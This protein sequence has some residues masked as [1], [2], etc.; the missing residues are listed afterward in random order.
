MPQHRLSLPPEAWPADLRERFETHPLSVHQRTRL[1]GAFGRWL[2]S[3]EGGG[4][5]PR[6]A[7]RETWLA[8]TAGLPR[9]LRN[10]VR[11]ALVIIFPAVATL[12]YEPDAPALARPDARLR[13]TRQIASNLARFPEDWRAAAQPL[14]H[15]DPD[16][17]VDG[18][19]VQAWAPATIVRRIQAAAL[20][21]DF[22]R[23]RGLE[24]DIKPG[25]VRAQLRADQA[26]VESGD[27]RIGG[28]SAHLDSLTCLAIAVRPDRSW[29]WLRI[30]RDAI[31]KVAKH[32]GSRNAA[33]AVDAAELRA[34]GQ[35]LLDKADARH[36]MARNRRDFV[37]AH[38]LARTALTMILLA[39]APVRIGSC[40]RIELR[41]SLL[42]DLDGL[43]LDASETKEKSPDRRAFSATLIDALSRYI[44]LHRAVIA[45]PGA[46]RLFV[47][48]RGGPIG[49]AQLSTCLGDMTEAPLQ[50]RVTP[51]AIRHSVANFIVAQVPEEA[52]L[53]TVIL[54]HRSASTT[55]VYLQ[56]AD[57]IIASRRLGA[58]TERAA[59]ELGANTFPKRKDK[60][61]RRHARKQPRC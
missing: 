54:N 51:H 52:A 35:Q 50:R 60:R 18:I 42:A 38:T 46:T 20:Y 49:A 30:T 19:L 56:R 15:V 44:R 9:S 11:Q 16:A 6:D 3:A 61:G 41:E 25:T 43:F 5:D 53:A 7:S 32:H 33:R 39:E 29:S 23:A 31:K 12:L 37:R 1:A 26:R 57:Q 14:L 22:C 24:V 45:R 59:R 17:V 40:A 36:A 8:Q 10:E 58:A 4:F 27:R 55:P 34:A 21:F 47:G 13:L 28:T 2:K 48:E